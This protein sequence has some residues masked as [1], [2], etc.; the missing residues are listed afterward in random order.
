MPMNFVRY[1]HHSDLF[2][3]RLYV[4]AGT[5]FELGL[6]EISKVFT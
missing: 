5:I 3:G 1:G 2:D 4:L 6:S